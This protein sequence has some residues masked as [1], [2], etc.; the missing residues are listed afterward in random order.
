MRYRFIERTLNI[1][2]ANAMVLKMMIMSNSNRHTLK[3]VQNIAEVGTLAKDETALSTKSAV[4]RKKV[5]ISVGKVIC[6]TG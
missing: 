1:C 4:G 5:D 2:K 3:K 6:I